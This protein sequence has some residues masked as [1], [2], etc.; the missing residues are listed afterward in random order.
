[1]VCNVIHFIREHNL[2]MNFEFLQIGHFFSS[3]RYKFISK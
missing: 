3:I 1:M 2:K